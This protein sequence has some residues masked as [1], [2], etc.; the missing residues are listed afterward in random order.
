MTRLDYMGR[1]LE[2]SCY[3]WLMGYLSRE[4]AEGIFLHT[5][6]PVPDKHH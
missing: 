4:I 6:L 5:L 2:K 1:L 3:M